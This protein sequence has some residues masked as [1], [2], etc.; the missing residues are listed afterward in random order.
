MVKASNTLSPTLASPPP[1]QLSPSSSQLVLLLFPSLWSFLGHLIRNRQ[2]MPFLSWP[3]WTY[4]CRAPPRPPPDNFGYWHTLN[5]VETTNKT[6][7]T[8]HFTNFAN[9]L[10][11]NVSGIILSQIKTRVILTGGIKDWNT[12]VLFVGKWNFGWLVVL[13]AHVPIEP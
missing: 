12:K 8:P 6:Q 2:R 11:S 10:D 1:L 9:V 13:C 4:P 5:S 7:S 3:E